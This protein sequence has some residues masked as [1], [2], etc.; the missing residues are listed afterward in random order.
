MEQIMIRIQ[1]PPEPPRILEDAGTRRTRELCEEYDRDGDAYRR[2]SKRF[3]FSSNVYGH[4]SVRQSLSAVQRDKC[5]YCESRLGV[6]SHK[7]V[8]HFRPKGA[9]QQDSDQRMEYPGYYWLAYSWSNLS[10]S[11]HVCN[12]THK[13][14]LFPL[15]DHTARARSHHDNLDGECPLFINPG[16]E[17]PRR[18][19]RF[20]GPAAVGATKRGQAT[21]HGLGLR[22][23]ALEE[24]RRERLARLKDLR[25]ILGMEEIDGLVGKEQIYRA[26]RTLEEAILPDAIYS[27]MAQDFLG[28]GPDADRG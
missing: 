27:S 18:H 13:R 3:N 5:C 24:A 8:E 23:S 6:T 2:G 15:A 14:S 9:V 25:L 19:I 4:D 10:M 17:D 28:V 21:I 16:L 1:R 22:R 11:C 20:R 7:V 12:S 26:R